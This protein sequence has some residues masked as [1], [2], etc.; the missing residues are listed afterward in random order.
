MDGFAACVL[1]CLFCMPLPCPVVG[2]D[3]LWGDARKLSEAGV[4]RT[5]GNYRN[6]PACFCK[7]TKINKTESYSLIFVIINRCQSAFKI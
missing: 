6:H 4:R 3:S 1:F 7:S 5:S 2:S